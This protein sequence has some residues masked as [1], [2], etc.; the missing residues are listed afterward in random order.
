MSFAPRRKAFDLKIELDPRYETN[1]NNNPGNATFIYFS[2]SPI[3]L[4]SE[5]FVVNSVGIPSQQ[6]LCIPD[7]SLE[8]GTSLLARVHMQIKRGLN[9]LT[10]PVWTNPPATPAPG[11][12]VFKAALYESGS[13][14]T[15]TPILT[16]TADK[17]PYTIR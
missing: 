7:I 10:D 8:P 5:I 4:S 16:V 11:D 12:F 17:L 13:N 1:P 2:D 3:D 9:I 15:G 14:C 6:K